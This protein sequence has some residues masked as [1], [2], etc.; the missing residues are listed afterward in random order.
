MFP[1]RPGVPTGFIARGTGHEVLV[2]IAIDGS[3][4]PA[5]ARYAPA[6]VHT[7]ADLEP[8]VAI[9]ILPALVLFPIG[10]V[11]LARLLMGVGAKWPGLLLGVGAVLYVLG[12][13]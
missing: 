9:I 4:N 8:G 2:L 1:V 12:G 6:L 5:V 13:F 10:Y 11:L 7:A 3:R